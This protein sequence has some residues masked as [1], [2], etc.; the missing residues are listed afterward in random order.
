MGAAAAGLLA[1]QVLAAPALGS[2][3]PPA[4]RSAAGLS[5][6]ALRA[7]HHLGPPRRY[8]TVPVRHARRVAHRLRIPSVLI[9]RPAPHPSW[10]TA[11]TAAVTVPAGT[12]GRAAAR[13]G[14][15]AGGWAQA[16]R[17]PVSVTAAAGAVP[18][19]AGGSAVSRVRVAVAGHSAA[20]A[21]GVAGFLFTISRADGVAAAGPVRVRV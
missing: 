12:P 2:V 10:P 17:L 11:G 13:R 3:P 15:A 9:A 6:A 21:A 4:P 7:A 20:R 19:G 1:V 18:A 14:S 8:K 16:G 5:Q